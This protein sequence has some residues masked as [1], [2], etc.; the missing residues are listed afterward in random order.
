MITKSAHIFGSPFVVQRAGGTSG[1]L[2]FP[3][4]FLSSFA[5]AP[6]YPSSVSL[7]PI[8]PL[9]NLFPLT[10]KKNNE[11]GDRLEDDLGGKTFKKTAPPWRAGLLSPC[12]RLH[13]S[14]CSFVCFTFPASTWE[15]ETRRPCFDTGQRLPLPFPAESRSPSCSS[16]DGASVCV[17]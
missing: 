6:K 10:R 1:V 11:V 13:L 7:A 15:G 17:W 4:T 14:A 16:E 9:G 8:F 5:F 2:R 3:I 12:L